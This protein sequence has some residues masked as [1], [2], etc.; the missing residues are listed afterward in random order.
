MAVSPDVV[1]MVYDPPRAGY[2]RGDGVAR[3]SYDEAQA[4]QKQETAKLWGRS[5]RDAWLRWRSI[6]VVARDGLAS[7]R[8][9]SAERLWITGMVAAR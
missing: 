8:T 5:Y 4:V 1:F 2:A 3:P 6:L 7:A 9:F